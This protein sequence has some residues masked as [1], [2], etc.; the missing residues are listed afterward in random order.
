MSEAD[1]LA[2]YGCN[3]PKTYLMNYITPV[4]IKC[5]MVGLQSPNLDVLYQ[6]LS[7]FKVEI[8]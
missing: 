7:V 5:G 4:R 6:V 1:S 3:I 8:W 2:Y